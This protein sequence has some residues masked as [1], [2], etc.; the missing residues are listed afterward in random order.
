MFQTQHVMG[1]NHP[2]RQLSLQLLPCS[3]VGWVIDQIIHRLGASEMNRF[4]ATQ[5]SEGRVDCRRVN[6]TIVTRCAIVACDD[7]AIDS[8]IDLISDVL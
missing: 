2:R 4:I 5:Y 7:F 3:L 6:A 8:T 1:L